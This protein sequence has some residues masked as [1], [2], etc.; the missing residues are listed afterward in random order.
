MPSMITWVWGFTLMSAPPMTAL[1]VITTSRAA[2]CARRRSRSAPPMK[3]VTVRCAG[4]THT[5]LRSSPL[6]DREVALLGRAGDD[7][8]R[9]AAPGGP[10]AGA[11]GVAGR[12][13]VI[14]T[15]SA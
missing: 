11:V 10:A 14:G 1:I 12:S 4:T 7:R 8:R 13:R 15:R 6:E 9:R 5:P 3:Q 2:N